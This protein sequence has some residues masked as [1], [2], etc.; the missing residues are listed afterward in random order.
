[1]QSPRPLDDAR[2]QLDAGAEMSPGCSNRQAIAGRRG[3]VAV[4]SA[5]RYPPSKIGVHLVAVFTQDGWQL[6]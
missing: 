1:M 5:T 4:A 3:S 6:I 2:A